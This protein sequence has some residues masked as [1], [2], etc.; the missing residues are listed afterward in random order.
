MNF[1]TIS[2][3]PKKIIFPVLCCLLL[4]CSF[5]VIA[6]S[7]NYWSRNFNEES[8]LLSGA[9]VGGG[10]GPAAIYY[11]PAG[12]GEIDE[13][14]LTI[15][16][17]LFS[18][19]LFNASNVWGDGKD[20]NTMRI[21]VVPRFIS[22][23]LQPQQNKKWNLEVAFLSNENFKVEDI[24]NVDDLKDV[25]E[26]IPGKER[27]NANYRYD[28]DFS[29]YWV[30]AGGSYKINPNLILGTSMFVTTRTLRYSY[31]VDIEAGTPV[32]NLNSDPNFK[33]A[34]F[35]NI[36]YLKFN[37][38]RLLWKFGLLYKTDKMS[39]GLNITTPSFNAYADGKRVMRKRSQSNIT[40]PETGEPVTDYLISDFAEVKD[41]HVNYK[42]PLSI[43]AGLSWQ[44]NND[45]SL[46][47]TLEYFFGLDPYKMVE[48]NEKYEIANDNPL[49]K[50]AYKE[51]LTYVWGAK[52]VINGAIGYRWIAKENL[53]V[54]TGFRTDFNYRKNLNYSPY[55]E[56]K[57]VKG[58]TIDRYHFTGGLT[59][60]VL[61]QDLMAGLQYSFGIEKNQQQFINLTD[62]VEFDP[63]TGR[64]L[65]GNPKN[66]V[67]SL[68]NSLSIY[69]GATFNFGK[70]E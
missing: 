37:N 27:Y 6:Q 8:S 4:F 64:A 60:H 17:S 51:W 31:M 58:F 11:N 1:V 28:N 42:N 39:Y 65:Q 9:V 32:K 55:I 40:N 13:S 49:L 3:L 34:K 24:N 50:E 67:T 38:Y 10:A 35:T 26:N 21:I 70:S 57:T 18:L 53:T 66:N 5:S 46:F 61:G 41:M 62:Y 29:D 19:E 12:I 30:G 68:S 56:S 2:T 20:L 14:K 16:A 54:M 52:P 47:L 43:A 36:E 45:K 25:L 22:Y 63:E 59:A 33:T 48:G 23:M 44:N 69:F 7:S 15:N